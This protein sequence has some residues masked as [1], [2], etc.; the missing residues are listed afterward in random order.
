MFFLL[1]LELLLE[2]EEVLGGRF[3]V[4]KSR[5]DFVVTQVLL[6]AGGEA[7][8]G[9]EAR[10]FAEVGGIGQDFGAGKVF[11][12]VD[13]PFELGFIQLEILGRAAVGTW[14]FC[15]G[16]IDEVRFVV[17]EGDAFDVIEIGVLGMFV[18]VAVFCV[19][20]EAFLGALE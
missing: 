13:I 8:G 10:G 5:V 15:E 12:E 9:D 18:F 6:F 7:V 1:A 20:E 19:V 14:V 11:G 3:G 16:V 17:G 2:F 4:G